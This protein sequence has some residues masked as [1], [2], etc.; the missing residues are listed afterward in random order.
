MSRCCSIS[1]PPFAERRTTLFPGNT[2]SRCHLSRHQSRSS[3]PA[4][5]PQSRRHRRSPRSLP[6]SF[7]SLI[8]PPRKSSP[9]LSTTT[10]SRAAFCP[11]ARAHSKGRSMDSGK[12]FC[13]EKLKIGEGC[14]F[15]T[16]LSAL[17]PMATIPA[18]E[19]DR[20]RDIKNSY[21]LRFTRCHRVEGLSG[22]PVEGAGR[23]DTTA[24][25]QC[26][27]RGRRA[28]QSNLHTSLT[29]ISGTKQGQCSFS[30]CTALKTRCDSTRTKRRSVVKPMLSAAQGRS[31]HHR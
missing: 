24:D 31:A 2:R 25:G 10:R 20:G 14:L 5:P 11:V 6:Q 12:P 3:L 21:P 15:Q 4:V 13:A 7:A 9:I 29:E 16:R 19:G 26:S 23:S 17:I 18:L 28:F 27:P 1:R 22:R 30:V 8:T